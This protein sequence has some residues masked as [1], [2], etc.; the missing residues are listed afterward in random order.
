M[1]CTWVFVQSMWVVS[2]WCR[3]LENRFSIVPAQLQCKMN[4]SKLVFIGAYIF[5]LYLMQH[6][7]ISPVNYQICVLQ[8]LFLLIISGH[9]MLQVLFH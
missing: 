3:K 7:H 1:M 6:M 9:L 4:G 5:Y 2:R 8:Q